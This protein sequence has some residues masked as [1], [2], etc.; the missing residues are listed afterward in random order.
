MDDVGNAVVVEV[1]GVGAF[2][3]VDVG[4][5]GAV[6]RVQVVVFTAGGERREQ[7]DGSDD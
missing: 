1:A 6:E 4:E 2:G 7:Q 5:L 3:E